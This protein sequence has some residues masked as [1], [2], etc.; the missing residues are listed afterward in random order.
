MKNHKIILLLTAFGMFSCGPGYRE[1]T[2]PKYSI[3]IQRVVPDSLVDQYREWIQE[4]IRAASQHM[5]GGEYE[6]VGHTI[7]QAK[8]TG[9]ELF[10]EPRKCL[11]IATSGYQDYMVP[12]Y[13]MTEE[14]REIFNDLLWQRKK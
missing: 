4:T 12:Q 11:I 5:S 14:Q 8:R 9:L 7:W 2:Y 13:Q 1:E 6:N 3:E 10:G